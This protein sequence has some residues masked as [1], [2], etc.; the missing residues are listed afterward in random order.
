MEFLRL[1]VCAR[2][3]NFL[4]YWDHQEHQETQGLQGYQE[5]QETQGHQVGG[6][7]K[8]L[9]YSKIKKKRNKKLCGQ[10]RSTVNS[11]LKFQVK[12]RKG[13]FLFCFLSLLTGRDGR[14][15]R[16]GLAGARGFPGPKGIHKTNFKRR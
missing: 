2:D 13:C 1:S 11:G 7:I 3:P 8:V 5:H 10:S 15:G 4:Y 9:L 12:T 14:D 6:Q 16:K